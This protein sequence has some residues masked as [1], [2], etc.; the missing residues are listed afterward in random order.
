M[1]WVVS[2]FGVWAIKMILS[3]GIYRSFVAEREG[4]R[5]DP[6]Q[7]WILWKIICLSHIFIG[8]NICVHVDWR[9]VALCNEIGLHLIFFFAFGCH[10][11]GV[12]RVG[13]DF[14]G[15]HKRWGVVQVFESQPRRG[16][17]SYLNVTLVYIILFLWQALVCCKLLIV[18][19]IV[20]ELASHDVIFVKR[21][22]VACLH[23]KLDNFAVDLPVRDWVWLRVGRLVECRL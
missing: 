10:D 7:R 23:V 14:P 17:L 16:F 4:L 5:L 22:I 3:K 20:C 6:W 2:F 1:S 21:R 11:K 19:W 12:W 9:S 8:E 13:L 18:N 15:W